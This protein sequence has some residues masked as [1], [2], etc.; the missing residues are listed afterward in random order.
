[1]GRRMKRLVIGAAVASVAV[2][3][4]WHPPSRPP[5]VESS[6]TRAPAVV[7]G[8]GKRGAG[9]QS[10]AVVYVV[11]AVRRAGLYRVPDGAR[12][13][14]AVRLAGGLAGDADAARVNLAARIADGDEIDVPAIGETRV[15]APLAK[16]TR[17]VRAEKRPPIIN[18]N[19]AGLSD[20]AQIPGIGKTIAQRIIDVRAHDGDFTSVDQLLDVA[21]MTQARLD[22]A[23][24]FLRI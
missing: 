12:I 9:F 13:D 22:R 18:I 20:F 16:R 11:G 23:Q 10:A 19:Q 3:A 17:G 21:G 2:V 24:D 6:P 5:I 8:R 1:M 15:A 4:L 14:D 7:H